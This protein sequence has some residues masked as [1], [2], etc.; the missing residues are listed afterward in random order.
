MRIH[1]LASLIASLATCGALAFDHYDLTALNDQALRSLEEGDV[2]T[3][4]ILLHRAVRLAPHDRRTADNVRI[5]E[6][7][8]AGVPL[9][10]MPPSKLPT[11][12]APPPSELPPAAAMPP[13]V[14][15]APPEPWPAK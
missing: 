10:A 8:L 1:R 9:P 4:C 3:A 13:V 15:P 12:T 5:L 2:M 11:P 6:A 14:P 7:H